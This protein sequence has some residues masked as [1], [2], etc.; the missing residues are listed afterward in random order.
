MSFK[1]FS[2]NMFPMNLKLVEGIVKSRKKLNFTQ[3]IQRLLSTD[4]NVTN[5]IPITRGINGNPVSFR[6][7][8]P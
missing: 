8:D 2:S 4:P 1:L 7:I 6:G 3:F 5:K